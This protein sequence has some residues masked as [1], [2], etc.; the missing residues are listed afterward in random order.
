MKKID[1]IILTMKFQVFKDRCE[2]V[3]LAF[4]YFQDAFGAFN[5]LTFR[6][7]SLLESY[8][9][10]EIRMDVCVLSLN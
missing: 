1:V 5:E 8:S 9:R 10:Q 7:H 3:P 6:Q 2:E 4:L